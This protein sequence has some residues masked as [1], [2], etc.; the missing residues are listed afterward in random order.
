[1][2][3]DLA[4]CISLFLSKDKYIQTPKQIFN[5]RLL[6]VFKISIILESSKYRVKLYCGF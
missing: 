3:Y 4:R 2:I 1:M 5:T 6:N